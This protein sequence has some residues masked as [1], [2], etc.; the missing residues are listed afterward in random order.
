MI[1]VYP[2]L[3][4]W[5]T[6]TALQRYDGAARYSLVISIKAPEV[7][8]DLYTEVVNRIETSATVETQSL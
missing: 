4:W 5:K 8:V 6:R 3:G 1:A 7:G 2:A